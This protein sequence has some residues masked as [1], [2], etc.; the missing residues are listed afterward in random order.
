VRITHGR[1]SLQARHCPRDSK[2][3]RKT[4]LGDHSYDEAIRR[5]RC[6][7]Y[8][9]ND[10]RAPARSRGFEAQIF[11]RR[12]TVRFRRRQSHHA[13]GNYRFQIVFGSPR[14]NDTVG[15]LAVCSLDGRYYASTLTSV[16]AGNAPAD[17]PKLVFSRAGDRASLSQLWEEGNPMGL[18]LR[19]PATETEL[20]VEHADDTLTIIPSR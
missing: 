15:V 20:A 2:N 16:A 4:D 6:G 17:G 19:A 7:A 13:R 12:R 11:C 5:N 8:R 3:I 14:Q 18:K 10:V 1:E 9:L